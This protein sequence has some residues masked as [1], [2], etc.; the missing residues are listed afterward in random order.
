MPEIYRRSGISRRTGWET[1]TEN[2]TEWEMPIITAVEL[3]CFRMRT[4]RRAPISRK[5]FAPSDRIRLG[6]QSFRRKIRDYEPAGERRGLDSGAT[7][8]GLERGFLKSRS[9]LSR[10]LRIYSGSKPR[11]SQM[12][13]NE[14]SHSVP[15]SS[16]HSNAF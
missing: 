9:R 6:R 5:R 16:T 10:T 11:R 12:L 13:L 4:V 3:F 1:F 14:K 15:S 8:S 7:F 2:S